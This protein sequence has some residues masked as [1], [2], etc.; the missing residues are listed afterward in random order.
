MLSRRR[1]FHLATLLFVVAGGSAFLGCA[2][3]NAGIGDEPNPEQDGGGGP[4][5]DASAEE[6]GAL[7]PDEADGG[8]IDGYPSCAPDGT[9]PQGALCRYGV[10]IPDRG[11]CESHG[12]C[13]G[14]SYCDPDPPPKTSGA[15]VPY[16]VPPGKVNDE[17]CQKLIDPGDVAPTVQCEWEDAAE[18][19]PTRGYNRIYTAPL[20]ADLNLDHDPNKLRPSIVVT[21]FGTGG[22]YP[23]MLRVFD[24]RTCTE[25]MRI[26]G[27]DDPDK[28]AHHPA[29]ATQWAIGDLDG[30]VGNAIDGHPEIVGFGRVGPGNSSSE[31]LTLRAFGIDTSD[32]D[33]PTLYR[34]WDGRICHASDPA[35]DQVVT[36]GSA[37]ANSGPGIWDLDDDGVPEI[38][39]D[40]MVFDAA[41]CLLNPPA[42][43][44]DYLQHGIHSTIADV[45]HDGRPDLVRYDG[46]YEWNAGVRNWERKAFV[47]PDPAA[48]KPGHVAVADMGNF[49]TLAGKAGAKLPEVVVVSADSMTFNANSTGTVRMQTLTG[50]IVFGPIELFHH[51]D[52]V[53]STTRYGGHGGPPTIGDFDGDGLPEI[54][55]AANQF[56]VV[57]DPDCTADGQPLPERPGGKCDRSG[58]TLPEGVAELPPGILWA[59]V[60]KDF[61]SSGT[62]SSI[63]DFN[64]DGVAEAVYRDECFLRVYDGPTGDVVFSVPARSGTGQEL[65]VIADVNGNFATQIVVARAGDPGGCP[66]IDPLFPGDAGVPVKTTGFAVLRDSEDAWASSR[67]IWNQHA[68]SVTNVLDDGRIPRSSDVKRNWETAHLNNF[69]QNVQGSLG[70]LKLADITVELADLPTVCAWQS[71]TF[72]LSAK[73]CNRGTNP[74]TDGVEIRFSQRDRDVDASTEPTVVCETATPKLLGVGECT[75]VT[76]EGTLDGQ[77]DLLV[78]AD[79]EGKIADCHPRSN[80]GASALVLCPEVK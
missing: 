17:S 67:P 19:D 53:S 79:P 25:Q 65:P 80:E 68:Y 66:A 44:V 6:D 54:G 35:L 24:G 57:Y 41:G 31:P 52:G 58:V 36:F 11:S 28:T 37:L 70:A 61:S 30:D 34:K 12:D 40:T 69:R 32:I 5:A 1:S 73:V 10:C 14:D 76:C 21:T 39:A 59:K 56:Y 29:Y 4:F 75:I 48:H 63:F 9:C 20:V 50:K 43:W 51:Y 18:G 8:G 47:V 60:S 62:G 22:N 45:D 13:L 16:G 71:G 2:P 27:P 74:V 77:R 49:S 23:S 3:K 46:S 42:A 33:N 26:G 64:G 15:C 7:P 72:T 55:V 38:I 78:Q